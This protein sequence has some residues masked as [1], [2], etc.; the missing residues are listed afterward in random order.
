MEEKQELRDTCAPECG[1]HQDHFSTEKVCP[2]CGKRLRLSG[3]LQLADFRLT[4]TS[5]GYQSP[6]LSMAELQEI[7]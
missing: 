5:C 7:I 2:N 1:C 3:N 4:C 6:R